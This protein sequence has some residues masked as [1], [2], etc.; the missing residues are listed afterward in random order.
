MSG[1][2]NFK[3]PDNP[4]VEVSSSDSAYQT[5]MVQ[6]VKTSAEIFPNKKNPAHV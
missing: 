6:G 1:R 2:D 5:M 3:L 4:H